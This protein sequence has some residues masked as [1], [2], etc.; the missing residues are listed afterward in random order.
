M[1]PL[2]HAADWLATAPVLL[3]IFGGA[4]WVGIQRLK[5]RREERKGKP[6]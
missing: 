3:V 5:E 4:A 1:T 6:K 2:A